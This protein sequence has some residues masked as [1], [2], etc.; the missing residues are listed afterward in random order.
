MVQAGTAGTDGLDGLSNAAAIYYRRNNLDTAPTD[1]PTSESAF[2]LGTGSLTP[3]TNGN[4]QTLESLSS[5]GKYLWFTIATASSRTNTDT[6]ATSEWADALLLVEDGTDGSDG[7]T[8][9]TGTGVPTPGQ[10]NDGDL[11]LRTVGEIIYKKANGA[12]TIDIPTLKGTD[13]TNPNVINWIFQ[14]SATLPATPANDAGIPTGWTDDSPA[15]PTNDIYTVQGVQTAGTGDYVWGTVIKLTGNTG[16]TGTSITATTV[17]VSSGTQV[18][19]DSSDATVADVV[20]NVDN[21]TDGSD[22]SNG[23]NGTDGTDGADGTRG[24]GEFTSNVTLTDNTIHTVGGTKFN[25]DALV[26]IRTVLGSTINPVAGDTVTITYTK[27]D[28]IVYTLSGV[29]SGV[30]VL[31]NSWASKDLQIDGSLIV[32][33]TIVSSAIKAG[34]IEA[35]DIKTG[36]ITT[37]QIATDTIIAGNIAASAITTSEL[38]TNSVTA[39]EINVAN[40]AAIQADLGNV[41]AGTIRGGTV[42]DANAAPSGAEKGSFFDLSSGKFTVGDATNSILFD[43]SNLTVKGEIVTGDNITIDGVTLK[44]DNGVLT[45]GTVSIGAVTQELGA[46]NSSGDDGVPGSGEAGDGGSTDRTFASGVTVLSVTN[47]S[48]SGTDASLTEV[49]TNGGDSGSV[50]ITASSGDIIVEGNLVANGGN[51]GSAVGGTFEPGGRGGGAGDVSNLTIRAINGNILIKGDV[52]ANGGNGGNGGNAG[53][54]VLASDGRGGP[55]GADGGTITLTASNGCVA[56]L[57]AITTVAG[58]A[59]TDGSSAGSF[60]GGDGGDAGQPGT[61]TLTHSSGNSCS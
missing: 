60:S 35:S 43:G 47:N 9:L 8:W 29:H 13:G 12:W 30:G 18:T 6:I 39:N 26:A 51:S 22:G 52:T 28:T 15:S 41:T 38:A 24:A 42:P 44:S 4:W 56:V 49:G 55:D 50:T 16:D 53:T 21:G 54:G 34:T 7:S 17:V 32:S 45:I 33:D 3:S 14:D 11:Y 40:I 5:T 25:T 27:L 1:K 57:G 58:S 31:D 36:T 19:I 59:G 37:T 61:V 23:T 48:G 10:G 46:I 2:N 20:F